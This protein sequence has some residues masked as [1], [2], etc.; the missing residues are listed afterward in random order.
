MI[1]MQYSIKEITEEIDSKGI[2]L[3]AVQRKIVWKEEQIIKRKECIYLKN[4]AAI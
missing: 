4:H 2:L 3:P 1:P